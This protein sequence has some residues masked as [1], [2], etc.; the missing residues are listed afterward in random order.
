MAEIVQN[1]PTQSPT[2][3]ISK[4]LTLIGQYWWV[5]LVFAIIIALIVVAYYLFKRNEE[6]NRRRDSAVYATAM[7]ISEAAT[8]NK[9]KAWCRKSYSLANLFW[10]G[11]PLKWNDHSVRL[12]DV[13]RNFLGWYRGAVRTQGGDTVFKLYKTKTFFF[14]EDDFLLYCPSHYLSG[15]DA[16]TKQRVLTP[17]P[18]NTIEYRV[19]DANEI[20]IK[21]VTIHKQGEYYFFP[22]YVFTINDERVHLDLTQYIGESIA[23]TNFLVSLEHAYSDMSRVTGRAVEVNP[24]LRYAQKEPDKEKELE[25]EQGPQPPQ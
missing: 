4:L 20:R 14:F 25:T 10:L 17:M 23:K 19:E 16:R 11:L 1:A 7:N 21:C 24:H 8:L 5:L 22:N 12:V 3:L 2:G 9:N 6:N 13:D 15:V 18:R